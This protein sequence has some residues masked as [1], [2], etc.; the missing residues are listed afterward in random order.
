MARV[1]AGGDLG[2]IVK[3]ED[4]QRYCAKLFND[5]MPVINGKLQLD[6]NI[7]SQTVEISFT[8]AN[9]QQEISHSLNK[10]GLRYFVIKKNVACDVYDGTSDSTLDKI[11]LKCTQVATVTI[12][13][14]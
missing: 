4:F 8:A 14:L 7:L 12:V 2:K 13:L 11:Y 5:L 10:T 3:I 9:T 6:E 1:L